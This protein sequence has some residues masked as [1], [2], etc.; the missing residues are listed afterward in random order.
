MTS[1]TEQQ[2]ETHLP[3]L[4]FMLPLYTREQIGK[5]EACHRDVVAGADLSKT[6][7]DKSA[8]WVRQAFEESLAAEQLANEW[9]TMSEEQ[10]Q[11][12]EVD[13]LGD[14]S[15]ATLAQLFMER[16][17]G[18]ERYDQLLRACLLSDRGSVLVDYDWMFA[19]V[20]GYDSLE[21]DQEQLRFMELAL[22]HNLRHSEGGQAISIMSELA[23][24]LLAS[25]QEQRAIEMYV[26]LLRHDPLSFDIRD[27]LGHALSHAGFR[28]LALAT[29]QNASELAAR[30]GHLRHAADDL[31]M[32]MSCGGSAPG[33]RDGEGAAFERQLVAALLTPWEQR[34]QLSLDELARELVPGIDEVP[35]KAIPLSTAP[36]EGK[37]P[38]VSA[39]VTVAVADVSRELLN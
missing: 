23:G 17:G 35:V 4:D 25:G 13:G 8:A 36:L 6:L 1:I 2:I 39:P 28:R 30:T 38:E 22:A 24:D 5:V 15:V 10:L 20:T 34:E 29:S 14:F 16:F 19:D 7:E 33:E 12:V 3:C 9:V 37:I 18:G 31:A 26:R 32:A 27:C 11:A 21:D